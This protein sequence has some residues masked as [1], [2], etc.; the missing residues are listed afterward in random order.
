M[1]HDRSKKT[2]FSLT[3]MTILVLLSAGWGLQ[4]KGNWNEE[5][6]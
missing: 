3:A 1:A 4:K 2:D 6:D 5:N